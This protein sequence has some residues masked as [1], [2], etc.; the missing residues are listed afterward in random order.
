MTEQPLDGKLGDVTR[1]GKVV[2]QRIGNP[3]HARDICENLRTKDLERSRRR[4]AVQGMFDGNAP[5]SY[6]ELLKAGRGQD[7][8]LNWRQHRGVV[9]NAHTPFFDMRTEVPVCIDGDL[10]ISDP[11]TD[12]ELMRGFAEFFH[13]MMFGWR[14]FDNTTQLCDLQ[15]LL[16][17]IGVLCW[18]NEWDW[19]PKSILAANIYFPD[20]C[21]T[22][23]DNCDYVVIYSAM[24]AGEL[25]RF[26][27]GNPEHTR[28]A[29]WNAEAVKASIMDVTET[30]DQFRNQTWEA[31]QA[32]FKNGEEQYISSVAKKVNVYH[33]FV[34]EMDG[35]ISHHIVP[36]D[37]PPGVGNRD[38]DEGHAFL[39]SD[40]KAGTCWDECVCLF[41]YDIGSDGTVHSVKGLGTDIYPYCELLNRIKNSLADVVMQGMKPIW[42]TPTASKL[43]DYKMV[44]Y[45]PGYLVPPGLT[46]VSPNLSNGIGPALEVSQDFTEALS[47][48]TAAGA[49]QDFAA[50]TVDETAK[51]ASLRH[52]NRAQVT[53]G[54]HNRYMRAVS[55][56]YAETWRRAINPKLTTRH[57]GGKEAVKFQAQCKR[58]CV[59]MGIPWEQTFTEE[60]KLDSPTGEPGKFTVL[61][62]VTNVRAN[63][64][65]GLGSASH[66]IEV[67][68]QLM[69]HIDRFDEA[70]QNWILRAFSSVMMN[71]TSVDAIVPSLTTG[72]DNTNDASVAANENN[73]MTALG[74][75]AE[76]IVTPDQNHVIHLFTHIPSAQADVKAC[77]EG[78]V[79]PHLCLSR[80]QAKIA[81]SYEHL[82]R[83][84]RNPNK[85]QQ[86]K[87]FAN[88]LK[89]L[90]RAAKEI[91]GVVEEMDAQA[92]EEQPPAINPDVLKVQ[93]NLEIKAQKEQQTMAMRA[94]KQAFDQQLKEQQAAHS[95]QLA[96]IDTAAAIERENAKT[97]AQIAQDVTKQRAKMATTETV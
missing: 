88:V 62:C 25:W 51:A 31:M 28:L 2:T 43:E 4:L 56:Q 47:Y 37:L 64:S 8:N 26:I 27:D 77:E 34:Q 22:S 7:A 70:G 38:E 89:Q 48:N 97:G 81:H 9:M 1:D 86:A 59:K 52:A 78:T 5:K 68:S 17:G 50:P 55:Q 15:M 18:Q 53:K 13:K 11:A 66:R 85:Q 95:R 49:T 84:M 74:A 54:M 60:T 72:R 33:M 80:L 75:E 12:S 23:L 91:A 79:D 21:E 71:Y 94:Q 46:N 96:D 30:T 40:K 35:T 90:E 45:G 3:R 93:G 42:S 10:Q 14:G 29:G 65:I 6:G 87:Q 69:Q 61:E 83:L 58:L 32:R 67:V 20:G 73:G 36:R 39:Y 63:Y 24:T 82:D 19:R 92:A 44:K 16:H 76:V 57:P 41:P